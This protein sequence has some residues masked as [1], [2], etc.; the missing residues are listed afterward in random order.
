MNEGKGSLPNR[1]LASLLAIIFLIGVMGPVPVMAADDDPVEGARSE[2]LNR[3]LNI[4]YKGVISHEK[5]LEDFEKAF[6]TVEKTVYVRTKNAVFVTPATLRA[7]DAAA[8]R[9]GKT[10]VIRCDTMENTENTVQ[11]RIFVEPAQLTALESDLKLGIFTQRS[12]VRSVQTIFE[13]SF[14]NAVRVIHCEQKGTFGARLRIAVKLDFSGMDTDNLKFFLYDK[15]SN[16]FTQLKDTNYSFDDN[17]FLHFYTESAGS[18]VI[19]D[20]VL[21]PK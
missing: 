13:R 10:A 20:S 12:K 9:A 6:S 16:R 19:A 21:Y 4:G 5:I 1:A 7:I 18:I 8:R 15:D 14:D 17:E 2:V 11:G 3:S